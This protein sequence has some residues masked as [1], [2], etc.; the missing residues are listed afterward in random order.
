MVG[1][2]RDEVVKSGSHERH[3]HKDK[4]Y[5]KTKHDIPGTCED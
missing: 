4:I 2:S 1:E 5:T 3:K